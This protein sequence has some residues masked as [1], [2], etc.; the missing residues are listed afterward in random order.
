MTIDK[1]IIIRNIY[2]MLTYAFQELRHNNYDDI[3]GEDFDNIL[4]L[5][6]EILFRGV[7]SQLKRGLHKD[8]ILQ[9]DNVPTIK[10][11]ININESIRQKLLRKKLMGC[12]FDEFSENNIHNQIL[13]S[14][15]LLLCKSQ[16]VKM[17]RRRKLRTLLLFFSNIENCNLKNI[18]WSQITYDRNSLTYHML[19]HFCYFV[20]KRM[21]LTTES[22]AYKTMNFDEELM[23]RLFEKFVLS[24]Y[25]KHYPT[26]SAKSAKVEWNIDADESTLS[27]I[28]EMKTDILLT[29][30]THTLIIDTKYY[31][32]SMQ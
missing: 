17:V 15:L 23:S 19:H 16:E 12:T 3:T 4:D 26:F 28:P 6:A 22:G 5:F 9:A 1:G 32:Q 21:L 13:K 7:S 10:G 20:I 8:Y 18:R 27:L 25:R 31:S 24:Y 11:K 30:P 29:F 14:T 2:Y